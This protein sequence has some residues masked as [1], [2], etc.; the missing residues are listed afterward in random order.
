MQE[1]DKFVLEEIIGI[2]KGV[3]NVFSSR[4][5]SYIDSENE[6]KGLEKF[7]EKGKLLGEV[8]PYTEL[9]SELN[10]LSLPR[11]LLTYATRELEKTLKENEVSEYVQKAG[12]SYITIFQN[13]ID[14][15][16]LRNLCTQLYAFAKK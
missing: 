1:K 5:N 8:Q 16:W 7:L 12:N 13:L 3:R 4:I 14:I 10:R 6:Q 2:V 9:K 15:D 11:D